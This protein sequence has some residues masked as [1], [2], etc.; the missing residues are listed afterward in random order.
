MDDK[1]LNEL[2]AATFRK[3]LEN[4]EPIE[5]ELMD[6]VYSGRAALYT[7]F[8]DGKLKRQ[9]VEILERP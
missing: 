1:A 5:P 4:Q 6:A 3:L 7:T 9:V 2:L 8:E